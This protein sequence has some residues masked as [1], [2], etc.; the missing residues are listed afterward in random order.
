MRQCP[1]TCPLKLFYDLGTRNGQP[2]AAVQ[3]PAP[4]QVCER[5]ES[6]LAER[7]W[8]EITEAYWNR[9]VGYLAR[10]HEEL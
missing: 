5:W 4:D 3:P 10:E 8:P 1:A 9:L 6:W 2:T 7:G